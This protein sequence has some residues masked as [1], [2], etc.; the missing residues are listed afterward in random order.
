MP[1][2]PVNEGVLIYS[3]EAK[4]S[5]RESPAL[6]Q[7]I[8]IPLYWCLLPK[9]G[10]SNLLEQTL[11][12]QQALPLLKGYKVI[13][14]GDGV[15]PRKLREF[16]SVDLRSSL[17]TRGGSFCLRLKKNHCLEIENL[18]WERL[19]QLGIVPKTSLYFPGVR[20]RKTRPVVWFDI[21]GKWKRNYQGLKVKDAWFILTDLGSLPVA[22]TAYKQ[23][24][25][26]EEM[27]RDCKTG[28]Y[29]LEGSGLRGER[30]IKMILLMAI[31]YTRAIFQG[32]EVQKK[33]VQKYLSRHLNQRQKYRRRSKFGVGLDAKQW[34]NYLDRYSLISDPAV[35]YCLP[36]SRFGRDSFANVTDFLEVAACWSKAS[37]GFQPL[38]PSGLSDVPSH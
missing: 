34:V 1:S 7:K 8:A 30:L 9:L 12:L 36:C 23:R 2:I 33:Q 17:K 18:I 22:I 6:W 10:N 21:A 19:D 38:V 20:V 31:V 28:G 3:R 27:F 35:A 16:S 29:S 15:P 4:L 14:L 25:G 37:L 13:V 24:M 32:T 5:R 11:A 26:I